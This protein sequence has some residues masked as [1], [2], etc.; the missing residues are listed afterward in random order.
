MVEENVSTTG[1]G[2]GQVNLAADVSTLSNDEADFQIADLTGDTKSPYWDP[3]H[4]HHQRVK[5]YVT[6]LHE[7]RYGAED[8]STKDMHPQDVALLRTLKESGL[9]KEEIERAPE[10]MEDYQSDREIDRGL[11]ELD[12]QTGSR[13]ETAVV[14]SRAKHLLNDLNLTEEDADFVEKHFG[15]NP[16]VISK[17]AEI[18]GLIEDARKKDRGENLSPKPRTTQGTNRYAPRVYKTPTKA[19]ILR[20]ARKL[21]GEPEGENE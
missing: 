7:H 13:K 8:E 9:T 21:L 2:G 5:D 18:M 20:Q 15:N 6:K 1:A 11:K 10:L 4:P 19:E 3:K 17:L 16:E 14:I 12:M